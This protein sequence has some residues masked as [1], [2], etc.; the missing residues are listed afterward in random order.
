[1]KSLDEIRA[2]LEAEYDIHAKDENT[3]HWGMFNYFNAG[4]EAFERILLSEA[5]EFPREEFDEVAAL[6]E[7]NKRPHNH[8]DNFLE[9]ARWQHQQMSAQIAAYKYHSEMRERDFKARV[10]EIE[11][12]KRELARLKGDA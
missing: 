7:W 5:P 12:L 9:G 11:Q 2:R 10:T 3:A 4:A 6:D 1:M 8:S